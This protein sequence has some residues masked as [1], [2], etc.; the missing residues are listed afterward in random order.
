MGVVGGG[1]GGVGDTG[2]GR[3]ERRRSKQHKRRGEIGGEAGG[4]RRR[5]WFSNF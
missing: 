5:N 1:C 2:W 4:Q 3:G